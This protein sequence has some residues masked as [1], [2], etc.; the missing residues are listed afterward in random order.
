MTFLFELNFWDIRTLI[1]FIKTCE[2]MN[3]HSDTAMIKIKKRGVYILISDP[4]SHC[5]LETRLT[6]NIADVLTMNCPQFTAK[7]LLDSFTGILRKIVRNKHGAV[8]YAV[9]EQPHVLLV[10]EVVGQNHKHIESYTVESTEHR[11]RVYYIISTNEFRTKSENYIQFRIPNIELNKI[12]SSQAII[13]GNCG[14]VGELIII[15]EPNTPL[16][17]TLTSSTSRDTNRCT[18]QFFLHNNSGQKGGTKIH[19]HAK[20]E[21]VPVLHAPQQP[22]HTKYF[23][24]Y[25]KRS[26]NLFSNPLD[27]I[28]MYVSNHGILLQTDTKDNHS[29]V[30]FIADIS[31]EDL[32]SYA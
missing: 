6:E 18:I 17:N 29:S 10:R 4:E 23:L 25:L 21:S 28:T 5:C 8:L 20:A 30:V 19:T 14:G 12:I 31:K 24:T 13:S 3:V 22:I 27:M 7:I 2:A 26:Q 1:A 9:P 11:A 15:P 16:P 32:N